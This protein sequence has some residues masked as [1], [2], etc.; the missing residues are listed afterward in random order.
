[1]AVP[2]AWT[3]ALDGATVRQRTRRRTPGGNPRRIVLAFLLV[4]GLVTAVAI[5]AAWP[6]N[7]AVTT[8]YVAATGCADT[9]PGT[10]PAAPLCHIQ[11]A[12]NKALQPGN[13]VQVAGGSYPELVTPKASGSAGSPI[14]FTAAPNAAV[15][16]GAGLANAFKVSARNWI[17][18]QGFTVSGTTSYG[19][20]VT[21]GSS[22]VTL[23][24]NSVDHTKDAGVYV[25]GG[26]NNAVSG[27]HV[28]YAGVVSGNTSPRQGIKLSG[29]SGGAVSSNTADHNSDA[30][31]QL[32]SGTTGITVTS[33][34]AFGNARTLLP[35]QSRAAPGIDVRGSGNSVVG[36]YSHDNEDSGVQDYSG[37]NDALIA[38]NLLTGNGDHGID[39]S[40]VQR[41]K[42]VENTVYRN[43]TSGINVE[44]S[45]ASGNAV[46]NNVAVDNAVFPTYGGLSCNRKQ[47]NIA[48][49]DA[50]VGTTTVD[51]NN[52]WLTTSGT[53]YYWAAKLTLAGFR[54][55]SGG[56]AAHDD[57]Y[58]PRWVGGGEYPRLSVAR[59]F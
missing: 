49:S 38:N 36:N 53:Q 32:A 55:A 14:V 12:A 34:E 59:S 1:M 51:H 11:A 35:G 19:I 22:N 47:G 15:T 58:D 45:T 20:Y 41:S 43:C 24:G 48:V 3:A 25:S 16:V 30:G 44:G 29:V 6:A 17:S 23:S 33:N 5:G 39:L 13:V 56:Q 8:Y 46:W 7:A 27:N 2:G 42:A 57:Y 52:T 40:N 54:A 4:L 10:D 26:S 50:G 31:I 28:S 18:I 9:N 21:S 37:G